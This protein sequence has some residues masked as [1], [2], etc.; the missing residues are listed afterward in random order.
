MQSDEW[1]KMREGEVFNALD[2]ELIAQR[3]RIRQAV[4]AFNRS[5]SKGHLKALL[6]LLGKHGSHCI[7]E[8]GVHIDYGCH[9]FLGDQVYFNAHCVILDAAP[10]RVG[11]N[12]LFGPAVHLYTVQHPL[13]MQERLS[14]V[15]WA[16]PI[17]IADGAW[18]GGHSVIMP[19]VTV[20]E[21]AVIGAGSVVTKD[22]PA[23]QVV[24]GN[25]AR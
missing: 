24:K 21:G 13:S 15:E 5:P 8:A 9:L 16:E 10:I 25:P 1:R 4:A 3:Q 12:V 6:S 20:G 17:H 18:I 22:V 23:G 2:Q 14:G 11:N 19:G 7:V